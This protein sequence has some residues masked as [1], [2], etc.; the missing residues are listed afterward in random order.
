MQEVTGMYGALIIEPRDPKPFAPTAS[1]C[2]AVGLDRQDPMRVFQAQG[3]RR[4]TS[5]T[6]TVFDFLRDVRATAWMPPC[7]RKMWNA[8]R[9]SPTDL[10]DLSP[11]C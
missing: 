2:A 4:V 10:A 3:P 8:M 5:T 6:P 7:K 11:P 1:T 9:M